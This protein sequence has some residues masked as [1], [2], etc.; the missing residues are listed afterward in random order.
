M[1]FC[2]VWI[3][4]FNIDIFLDSNFFEQKNSFFFSVYFLILFFISIQN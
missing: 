4:Y 2:N 1:S 3:S